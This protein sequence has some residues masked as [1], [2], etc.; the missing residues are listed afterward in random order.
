MPS[1]SLLSVLKIDDSL[2]IAQEARE[3]WLKDMRNPLRMFVLPICRILCSLQLHTTYFLKRLFPIQFNAHGFLQALI[4]WFMKWWITPE[5]NIL[6]LRH[7]TTE[8]NIINFLI[9]NSE[10]NNAKPLELYPKT[11]EDMMGASLVDHDQEL[12][13][14]MK[15]LG[16]AQG[17]NWPIPRERLDWSTWRPMEVV[18]DADQR[19]WTQFLDFETAHELFKSIFCLFLTAREYE[20]AINGF[21]LDQSIAIRIGRILDDPTIPEM[22]YNKYPM[23]F[24]RTGEL[25]RRFLLHGFFTE[26]LH[27][28]LEEIR[29]NAIT[30][31]QQA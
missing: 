19:K 18:N 12:F 21:Q 1:Q 26:H 30:N 29:Q 28:Y 2:P 13:R 14:S 25:T 24:V 3:L 8:S 16:A 27:A 5:A 17:Q 11:I 10:G 31:S 22:A 7:Y 6:I 23:L 4:C 9:A 15:E 20:D